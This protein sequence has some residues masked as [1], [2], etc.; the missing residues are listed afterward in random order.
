MT[1]LVA[2][3]THD[4][5]DIMLL[6]F[7]PFELE[8]VNSYQNQI[9]NGSEADKFIEEVEEKINKS[10]KHKLFA[11]LCIAGKYVNSEQ[12]K[13]LI[14]VF[15]DEQAS[16]GRK[17][18]VLNRAAVL[19]QDL[20]FSEIFNELDDG[21]IRFILDMKTIHTLIGGFCMYDREENEDVSIRTLAIIC[22]TFAPVHFLLE[23]FE[24]AFKER[25]SL[26]EELHL[27]QFIKGVFFNKILQA[28][29]KVKIELYPSNEYDYYCLSVTN[30]ETGKVAIA[31]PGDVVFFNT[32]EVLDA[33]DYDNQEMR[34]KVLLH[35]YP[36]LRGF[37]DN[38]NKDSE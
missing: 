7:T 21:F 25:T 38:V 35:R 30:V 26:D 33:D 6:K 5:T 16:E 23:F 2:K 14:E 8:V 27:A 31:K 19:I 18:F 13:Q 20:F 37:Q 10:T 3:D 1:G 17:Q 28:Q 24:V 36:H 15:E 32:G 4:I 11:A 12:Y 22:H 29:D 34:D 9:K